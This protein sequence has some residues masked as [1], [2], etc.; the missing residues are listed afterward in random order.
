MQ[1]RIGWC[2]KYI[3]RLF[4]PMII[5]NLKD[6]VEGTKLKKVDLTVCDVKREAIIPIQKT[7]S[8]GKI[9]R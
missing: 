5:N 6:F 3:I 4:F 1:N 8:Q 9:G 2:N 7:I